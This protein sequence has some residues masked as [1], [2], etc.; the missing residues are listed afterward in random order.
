M[1]PEQ[2]RWIH[3]ADGFSYLHYHYK[4]VAYV[5][6]DGR[7]QLQGWR[8]NRLFPGSSRAHSVRMVERW[9]LGRIRCGPGWP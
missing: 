1:L 5:Y 8:V 9:V 2:Y 3:A 7:V 6:P 4:C